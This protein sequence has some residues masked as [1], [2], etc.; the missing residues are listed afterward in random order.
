MEVRS[1]KRQGSVI[2]TKSFKTSGQAD[3][4]TWSSLRR[5][6][7]D[8]GISSETISEKRTFIIEWFKE[9]V[10]AGRL[11]EEP[12]E[13]ERWSLSSVAD[14]ASILQGEASSIQS[15]HY[16]R[17][18][19]SKSQQHTAVVYGDDEHSRTETVKKIL[20]EMELEPVPQDPKKLAFEHLT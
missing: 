6:L 11:E 2:S 8:V 14:D 7:E 18:H 17:K 13:S 10:A 5:E 12:P 15:S 9:A 1:G 20:S 3:L 4:E 16:L 19:E